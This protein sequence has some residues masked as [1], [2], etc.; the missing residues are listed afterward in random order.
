MVYPV[1]NAHQIVPGAHIWATAGLGIAMSVGILIVDGFTI[2]GGGAHAATLVTSVCAYQFIRCKFV[3]TGTAASA[4][5][6]DATA[7]ANTPILRDCVLISESTATG[8]ITTTGAQDVK[9]YGTTLANKGSDP[10]TSITIRCGI[11]DVDA[12]VTTE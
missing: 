1:I 6:I 7:T 12:D 5:H 11:Y 2:F 10:P 8:S 3:A 4:I 9:V